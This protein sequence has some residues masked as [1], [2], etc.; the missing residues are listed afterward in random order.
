MLSVRSLACSAC[1]LLPLSLC[2]ILLFCVYLYWFIICHPQPVYN[3]SLFSAPSVFVILLCAQLGLSCPATRFAR[4]TQCTEP[5][6]INHF[7]YRQTC[8]PAIWCRSA[9]P[10]GA[11]PAL[12]TITER[13]DVRND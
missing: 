12:P 2:R 5:P 4:G 11:C 6:R 1:A 9:F 13:R 7:T 3:I 8:S 10:L